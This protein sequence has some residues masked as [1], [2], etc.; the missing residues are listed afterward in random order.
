MKSAAGGKAGST[1]QK[2][3]DNSNTLLVDMSTAIEEFC[4]PEDLVDESSSSRPER[5]QADATATVRKKRERK[6]ITPTSLQCTDV[7]NAD[8]FAARWAGQARYAPLR[9]K[10]FVWDGTRWSDDCLAR[11]MEMAKATARGIYLEAG[12]PAATPGQATAL[13]EW[14]KRSMS[15]GELNSMLALAQSIPGI[16]THPNEFDRDPY[17]LNTPAGT[18][19]LRTGKMR[20]HNPDDLIRQITKVAPSSATPTR[21]LAFL[22]KI[23]AG[24]KAMINYMH[25]LLGYSLLGR[26]EQHL[27][28]ICWGRGQNGKSTL[29]ETVKTLLGD[30]GYTLPE[31]AL[32]KTRNLASSAPW[33]AQLYG[34]RFAIGAE[35]EREH[36]LSEAFVNSLTGGDTR[37]AKLLYENNFEY[38]PSDTIFI[39]TNYRPVLSG[40]ADG[41]WRRLRLVPFN[42]KIADDELIPDFGNILANEEG[43]AILGWLIQGCVEYLA[44][45]SKLETPQAVQA[46]TAAY[47]AESDSVGAF[48]AV[49][50]VGRVNTSIQSSTLHEMY[51]EWCE[52]TGQHMLGRKAFSSELMDRGFK[53]EHRRSGSV[54]LGLALAGGET[55]A[56]AGAATATDEP[57]DADDAAEF[58][59]NCIELPSRRNVA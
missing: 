51:C 12:N 43:G 49:A 3:V 57:D 8:R 54:V 29:L 32:V 31:G 25:Q 9:K 35:T 30:Y 56:V 27:L 36:E 59:A 1:N 40:S 38:T 24:D 5:P 42:V 28:I 34:K 10:W 46:A 37:N 50:T 39:S 2:T 4:A 17:L 18:V 6:P 55:P 23:F 15:S 19:D 7:A 44:S 13:G 33:F 45:G 22:D 16:A 52:Q 58:G 47:R 11:I 20:A 26:V 48:L 41:I 53:I 14:A 21:W